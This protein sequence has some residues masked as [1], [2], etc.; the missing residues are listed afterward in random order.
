MNYWWVNQ[1][2]SQKH[3]IAGGFIWSPKTKK[4]GN[5]HESYENLA[6]TSP[7]D[8]V[9]SFARKKLRAV[10]VVTGKS[11]DSQKPV[12][13]GA[14]GDRWD[15]VGHT[16]PMS[17]QP[18]NHPF[19]PGDYAET[20][21]PLFAKVG[22]PYCVDQRK[23]MQGTYLSRIKPEL[24]A[25]IDTIAAG[26]DLASVLEARALANELAA[27]RME[28]E[29]RARPALDSTTREALVQ[30]RRGQG[31][32]RHDLIALEGRCRLTETSNVAFL[33]ASHIKPWADSDDT[34]RLDPHNGLLLAPHV[35]RLFDRGWISFADDGTTLIANGDAKSALECWALADL[36]PDRQAFTPKQRDYLAYHRAH[37]FGK[38]FHRNLSIQK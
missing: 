4:N 22:R 9:F 31:R 13:F 23:G 32:F 26:L 24:A 17:W 7:G 8:I 36:Q 19:A 16:V 3:Q 28:D 38:R 37:I 11:F 20:L 5:R 14:D 10:G 27:D 34:E 25:A 21:R 6:E 1:G 30:A 33:V 29:I 15:T 2:K 35:D 12:Q 18:F